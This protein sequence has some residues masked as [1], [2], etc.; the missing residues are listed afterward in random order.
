M[1]CHTVLPASLPFDRMPSASDLVRIKINFVVG[2]Q[3]PPL[4]TVKR[5]KLEQFGH[6][7]RHECLLK[8]VLQAPWRVG[9]VAVG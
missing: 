1:A 7:M 6:V 8:T 5:Q 4:A 3:E 2:P 9:D